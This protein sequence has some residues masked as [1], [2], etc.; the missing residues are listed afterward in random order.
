MP[1]PG[2]LGFIRKRDRT[3]AQHTA[4]ANADASLQTAAFYAL[5][6]PTLAT[7]QKVML[8]GAWKDPK[9]ITDVGFPLARSHQFTGSCVN[10]GGWNALVSTICAQRVSSVSPRKAFVPFTYHNYAHSRHLNGDDDP[11]EGS[12]GSTFAASLEQI[13]V[14]DWNGGQEG[15]PPYQHDEDDGFRTDAAT[16]TAWSSWRDPD[17][18]KVLPVASRHR[19]GKAARCKTVEDIQR[20]LLN[21]YGVAIAC[22]RYINSAAVEGPGNEACVIGYWDGDGGHQQSIHGIWAHPT[23]GPLYAVGNSWDKNTYPQDP[24]GLPWCF[25]WVREAKVE[26]AL[27]LDAEV[28]GYS[29]V[30]WFPANPEI[31]TWQP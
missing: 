2:P 31:V 6:L 12:F 18:Q 3:A 25:C 24:A 8:T 4:A 14:R 26:E 13:G 23:F 15:M 28:Y 7:G 10:S 17:I 11:G 19:L 9:V 22:D 30:P 20:M 5:P 16:E 21:G 29:D 27:K 1:P